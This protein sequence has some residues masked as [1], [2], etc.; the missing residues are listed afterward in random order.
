MALAHANM[1]YTV[2]I[3][4]VCDKIRIKYNNILWGIR[5]CLKYVGYTRHF[6][7]CLQSRR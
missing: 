1:I 2:I 5:Q 7:S 6:G 3:L 4:N